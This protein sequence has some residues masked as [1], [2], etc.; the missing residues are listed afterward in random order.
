MNQFT[1][2]IASLETA[3]NMLEGF[4]ANN[5]QARPL[6]EVE[7][8]LLALTQQIGRAAL[9][10]FIGQV[11]TGEAG[12][13][14][15]ERREWRYHGVRETTYRSIFGSVPIRR[16]YYHHGDDGGFCPLDAQLAL[17]ERSYSYVLQ[18]LTLAL[19][20]Q[21]AYDMARDTLAGLLGVTM[22]KA[23]AEAVVSEAARDVADF[24]RQ[25]EAPAD[26]GEVLVIQ[27]D[28]KGIPMVRPATQEPG[29]KMRR[30]KGQKR[31]KKKMATVFTLHTLMPVPEQQPVALNRKTYGFLTSKR[32][33]FEQIAAE[34]E[35]RAVGRTR[36]LFLSDGDP[37][38]AAL[39][40][41]FFP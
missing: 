23:M 19:D 40:R 24:Q 39:Q 36:V 14:L 26:E 18:G 9:A 32:E 29:P 17:P 3:F 12:T 28:G 4:L 15:D 21:N 13:H 31:N 27:A 10:H 25:F 20:A 41:E 34:V 7:R 2:S 33:A 38:L 35:K 37:D 6:H 16:A 11:G 5:T 30:K 22:P 8:D 1:G